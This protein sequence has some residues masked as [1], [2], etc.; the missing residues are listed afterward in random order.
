MASMETTKDRIAACALRLFSAHGYDGV[1]VQELCEAAGITKPSL[2]HHFGNK[3]GLLSAV[4]EERFAPFLARVRVAAAYP[5]EHRGDL[6]YVLKASMAAFLD[7]AR[8]DPDFSRLRL[9]VAFGPPDATSRRLARPYLDA[10]HET[11]LSTFE[12]AALEHGN[13]AGRAG[14]YATAFLGLAD[15]YSGR[16]LSGELRPDEAFLARSIHYFMHGIFS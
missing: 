12:A 14:A 11:V 16:V 6:A 9:S 7:A 10:L 3:E 2:Y 1:G 8:D 5:G 15:A 4:F 13:M